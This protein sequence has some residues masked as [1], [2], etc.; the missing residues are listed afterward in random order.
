MV[1]GETVGVLPFGQEEQP[2]VDT[3]WQH[4]VDSLHG[5]V[6]S[7]IVIVINQRDII[8]ETPQHP[9]LMYAESRS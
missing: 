5:S 2:Y 8:G 6:L 7:S 3:L 1:P 9:G 4:H